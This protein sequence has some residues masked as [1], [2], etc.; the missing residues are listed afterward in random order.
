[1]TRAE[2]EALAKV[3]EAA[4][5]L[6]SIQS[7]A[8]GP[9]KGNLFRLSLLLWSIAETHRGSSDGRTVVDFAYNAWREGGPV[10]APR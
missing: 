9:R 6:Y 10:R 3:S 4:E 7:R 1:M 2:T 8:K 5:A